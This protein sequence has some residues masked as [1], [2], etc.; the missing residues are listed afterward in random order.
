MVGPFS[1]TGFEGVCAENESS[2]S[3][4]SALIRTS[5]PRNRRV[6]VGSSANSTETPFGACQGSWESQK[7]GSRRFAVI[8][9]QSRD[10][11]NQRH[12]GSSAMD[13]LE[14][15]H[16]VTFEVAAFPILIE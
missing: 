9:A 14:F 3:H 6:P 11:L 7:H 10:L 16:T 13:V 1:I 8:Q 12:S 5:C 4:R 15:P 2:S